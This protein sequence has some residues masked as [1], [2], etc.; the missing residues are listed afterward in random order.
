MLFTRVAPIRNKTS[1]LVDGKSV[2]NRQRKRFKFMPRRILRST[3]LLTLQYVNF[4]FFRKRLRRKAKRARSRVLRYNAKV[5]SRFFKLKKLQKSKPVEI[6]APK[7][8]RRFKK[9]LRRLK[10]KYKFSVRI[11]RK[12]QRIVKRTG[13][14]L[15]RTM[16]KIKNIVRYVQNQVRDK[17]SVQ[18]SYAMGYILF[19]EYVFNKLINLCMHDG[20]KQVVLRQFIKAL[21]YIKSKYKVHPN[22]II[23]YVLLSNEQFFD[24]RI[25]R[26]GRHKTIIVPS[27]VEGHHRLLKP[28]RMILD[29]VRDAVI[30]SEFILEEEEGEKKEK[31]NTVIK[32]KEMISDEKKK[33]KKNAI[34]YAFGTYDV[35]LRTESADLTGKVIRAYTNST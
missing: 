30:D 2:K 25:V 19:N 33:K 16:S 15:L 23:R 22:A 9:K 6:E 7:K 17:Y 28:L 26:V 34:L 10:K 3:Q 8:L 21:K 31:N 12:N 4:A 13:I 29:T 20:R 5:K 27:F 35:I 18:T 1:V 11:L 14:R 32:D 24:Y